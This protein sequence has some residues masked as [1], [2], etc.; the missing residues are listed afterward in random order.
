[1]KV[2][3]TIIF[4]TGIVAILCSAKLA[5]QQK[6]EAARPTGLA[7]EIV[8]YKG[9]PPA[10]Q[11]VSSSRPGGGWFAKFRHLAS[12]QP[13]Q[14]SLPVR[15]V[16][17]VSRQE[18]DGVRVNLSVFLGVT[19]HDTEEP[20]A[21]Y[22][23]REN[24]SIAANEL[25]RFG[26]EPFEITLVKIAPIH[27]GI[28]AIIN[29]SSSVEVT[30]LE[31]NPETLPSYTLSLKNLSD[32]NIMVI[33][34]EVFVGETSRLSSRPQDKEGVP[35]MKPGEVFQ[36]RVLGVRDGVLLR[37]GSVPN[38]IQGQSIRIVAVTFHD[39]S[40][41]GDPQIAATIRARTIGQKIQLTQ[42]ITFLENTL[43]DDDLDS[44]TAIER[45]RLLATALDE[46]FDPS[47]IDG[48]VKEV[49]EPDRTAKHT[50]TSSLRYSLHQIKQ[51]LLDG[52]DQFKKSHNSSSN[53]NSFRT[54]LSA[55]KARYQ[56]WLSRL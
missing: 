5:A 3:Q 49:P 39:G 34:L 42:T 29:N 31:A 21:T 27:P 56:Q 44:S 23:L 45:F 16:N 51:D 14:D 41:E 32:K 35:L 40:F 26:V 25:T 13:P 1:V 9:L 55:T 50:I 19:Y 37:Q 38:I 33:Q 28:P 36:T 30:G 4:L 2:L 54:W 8:F 20:V 22:L 46:E 10:Y 11:A 6:P 12:W 47:V 24:E 52:L 17:I 43:K 48:L 15:A 18:A 7:L 53:R